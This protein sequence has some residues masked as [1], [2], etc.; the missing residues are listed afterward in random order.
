[1]SK[2]HVTLLSLENTLSNYHRPLKHKTK[3]KNTLHNTLFKQLFPQEFSRA[4]PSLNVLIHI[5]IHS[6]LYFI[7]EKY[8]PKMGFRF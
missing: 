6:L 2:S 1:M 3:D 7:C 5:S 4:L 8:F